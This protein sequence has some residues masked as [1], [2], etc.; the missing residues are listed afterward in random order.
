M[1]FE[2]REGLDAHVQRLAA[3][4]VHASHVGR[5]GAVVGRRGAG[6]LVGKSHGRTTPAT[7]TATTI[8]AAAADA[9]AASTD[10]APFAALAALCPDSFEQRQLGL[11]HSELVD[12]AT[13]G[14][15]LLHDE[16]EA[17][18]E[19]PRALLDLPPAQIGVRAHR[20]PAQLGEPE[21]AT[22]V[23]LLAP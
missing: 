10:A 1:Q 12:G 2:E 17:M 16:R 6:T 3:E 13:E 22:E 19:Q 11:E 9:A 21:E 20:A 5:R 18:L 15:S 8:R 7:T 4:L 23:Q 14:L